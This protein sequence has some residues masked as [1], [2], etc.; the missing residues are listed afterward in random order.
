M[1][2]CL[3][4]NIGCWMILS[5]ASPIAMIGFDRFGFCPTKLPHQTDI[6][7]GYDSIIHFRL[8]I[9]VSNLIPSSKSKN[10]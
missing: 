5:I 10:E 9:F 4:R 3:S 2:K 7:A 6:A 1:K 8:Q